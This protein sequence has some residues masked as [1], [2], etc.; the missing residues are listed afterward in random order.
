MKFDVL[1]IALPIAAENRIA[2]ILSYLGDT[3]VDVHLVP[4]FLLSNL[5]HSRIDHVGEIDTLSVFE[6]PYQGIRR[7]IKRSEDIIIGSLILS[8]I[9]P[10]LTIIAV[11]IKLTSKG[12]VLFKQDRYGLSGQKI[13]VWKFRSMSVMEK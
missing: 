6:S 13:K 11:V 5:M 2:E 9:L 8:A 3:T 1:F 10:I 12:P 4:D 7:L